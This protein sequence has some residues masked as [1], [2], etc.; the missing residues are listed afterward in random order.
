MHIFQINLYFFRSLSEG[1][2][3]NACLPCNEVAL[4]ELR[5]Q[6]IKAVKKIKRKSLK[7]S[8]RFQGGLGLFCN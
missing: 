5:G 1:A 2:I 3:E 4:E 8:L 6:Y 7:R